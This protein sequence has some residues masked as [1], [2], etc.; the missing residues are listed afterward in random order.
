MLQFIL[1]L[2]KL[3]ELRSIV[4]RQASQKLKTVILIAGFN[5]TKCNGNCP[6][7]NFRCKNSFKSDVAPE[8]VRGERPARNHTQKSRNRRPRRTGERDD[9]IDVYPVCIT[10]YCAHPW[11]I[12]TTF[13]AETRVPD[14]CLKIPA[15]SCVVTR[16]SASAG[17]PWSNSMK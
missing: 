7:R 8:H 12:D 4:C 11:E 10:R 13:V 17:K 6:C 3:E 1:I 9:R 5:D 15:V 16:A 2:S 14:V